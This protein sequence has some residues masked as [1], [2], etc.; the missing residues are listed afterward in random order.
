[1]KYVCSICGY[2]YDEAAGDPENGV[3]PGTAWDQ[4]PEGW[5]CPRCGAPKALFEPQAGAAAQPGPAASQQAA[6]EEENL[7]ELTF[8]QMSALCSNLAKGCEKQYLAREAELFGQLAEYYQS[9]AGAEAPVSVQPLLELVERDLGQAYPAAHEQASSAADRGAL[10]VLVWSEKV[11]RIL[12]SLLARYQKEGGAFLESTGVF[13]C[14][15]CG[16]VYVGDQPPEI[17][18]VCKVPSFKIVR[19]QRR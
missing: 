5:V 4:L 16:F 7:R 11:S 14:D 15:I 13:V 1:M 9:R 12:S 10:R 18:P 8:G 19:L 2:V 6:G 17:C 3:S